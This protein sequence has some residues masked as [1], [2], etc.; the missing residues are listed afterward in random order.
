MRGRPGRRSSSLHGAGRH[1][2]RVG[3]SNAAA[4]AAVGARAAAAAGRSNGAAEVP[5]DL[6]HLIQGPVVA[7]TAVAS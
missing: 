7:Q 3:S 4:V 5:D 1:G 6:W 2:A